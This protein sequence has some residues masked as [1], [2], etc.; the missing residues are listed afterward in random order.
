MSRDLRNGRPFFVLMT[1][2]K[3]LARMTALM[4]SHSEE[5]AGL[6]DIGEQK[7]WGFKFF[8]RDNQSGFSFDSEVE[9]APDQQIENELVQLDL[10]GKSSDDYVLRMCS[11]LPKNQNYEVFLDHLTLH[12]KDYLIS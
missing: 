5:K 9:G 11:K 6:E 12:S 3:H 8:S 7:I 1:I 10:I 4:I 2:P